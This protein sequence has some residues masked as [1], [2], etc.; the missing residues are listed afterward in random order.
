MIVED[1]PAIRRLL[2]RCI[3]GV[4]WE[5]LAVASCSEAF[6][7]FQPGRFKALLSDVDLGG[8][9]GIELAREL[10]LID[11]ALRVVLM[12]GMPVN[13]N[14]AKQAGFGIFLHKPLDLDRIRGLLN[15]FRVN[16]GKDT[17]RPNCILIVDDD[18]AVLEMLTQYVHAA[19]WVA[20]A[21][22]SGAEALQAFQTGKFHM[23]VA[24]V[25]LDDDM[26]GIEV[27]KKLL[28][29]EPQ[30][31]VAMISGVPGA[32]DRVREAGLR[33]FFPKP[34]GIGALAD[35]LELNR[36]HY[37]NGVSKRI[38]L[39]EDDAE[40]LDEYCLVLRVRGYEVTAVQSAEEALKVVE[41]ERFDVILTDN[42]LPGMTGLRAIPELRKRSKAPIVLMT[43]H[44][45]PD[46]EK[47]ALLL[48]AEAFLEK[49]LDFSELDC[50]LKG[51]RKPR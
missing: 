8:K 21:A 22:R 34:V 47:D 24:D 50:R 1:D 2:T 40:Q 3:Q 37:E 16:R 48:G 14:K 45:N 23:L 35:L 4:G 15:L 30:L 19:G 25:Q 31:K 26:D 39:V 17:I 33:F 6:H 38:L 36:A 44:P 13:E 20:V 49:P 5:V 28:G 29:L 43:S 51:L 32:S 18:P 12:S 46:M 42:V 27:A 10:L 9:N 11:P 41:N 7:N